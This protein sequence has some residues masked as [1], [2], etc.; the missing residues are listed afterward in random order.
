M[1]FSHFSEHFDIRTFQ[2]LNLSEDTSQPRIRTDHCT[3]MN[4]TPHYTH[5]MALVRSHSHIICMQLL[6]DASDGRV[7]I[8][9]G[10]ALEVDIPTACQDYVEKRQWEDGR[11]VNRHQSFSDVLV[12]NFDWSTL[13]C[14]CGCNTRSS[15][16]EFLSF[17]APQLNAHTFLLLQ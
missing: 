15:C 3:P 6:R 10:D 12:V 4:R 13:S 7:D 1:V 8:H 9:Y 2:Y 14:L 16:C 5:R 17:P 11:D